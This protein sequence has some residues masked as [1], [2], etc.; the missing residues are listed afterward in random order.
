M[1][2]P[3]RKPRGF[4]LLSPEQRRE[5]ASRGGRAVRPEDRTF[6][7]DR[8]YARRMGRK[9]GAAVAPE[10]R[11]FSL[12]PQLAKRAGNRSRSG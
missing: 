5:I 7:R 3:D 6:S 10:K 1:S 12:D 8:A 11:T 9:G 2:D 4:A